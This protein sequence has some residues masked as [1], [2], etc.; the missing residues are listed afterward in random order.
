MTDTVGFIRK[1]PP[2]LIAAFKATLEELAEA[3]LLIH[4]VDMTAPNAGAQFDTVEDILKD[5]HL[6]G[7]P[8]ITAMNKI[9]AILPAEGKWDEAS[10]LEHYITQSG[11]TG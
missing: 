11:P 5:L 1:L 4:V 6:E 2:T 9:D 3:D 10:A 8:V 7:K